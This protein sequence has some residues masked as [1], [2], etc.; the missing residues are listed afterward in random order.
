MIAGIFHR[1]VVFCRGNSVSCLVSYSWNTSV[2][3]VDVVL[4]RLK[5]KPWVGSKTTKLQGEWGSNQNSCTCKL[6]WLPPWWRQWI[7]STFTKLCDLHDPWFYHINQQW[8]GRTSEGS[9]FLQCQWWKVNLHCFPVLWLF[10]E[11]TF[12]GFESLVTRAKRIGLRTSL[13]F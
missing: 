5:W 1:F 8:E 12:L 2:W 9:P 4:Q 13:T 11:K 10:L 3:I 7:S 6:L